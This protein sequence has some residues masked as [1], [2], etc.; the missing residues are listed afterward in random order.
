MTALLSEIGREECFEDAGGGGSCLLLLLCSTFCLDGGGTGGPVASWDDI[1]LL[2]VDMG[3][4]GGARLEVTV[5]RSLKHVG[6]F[7][8]ALS[9]NFCWHKC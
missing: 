8:V 5:C 3:V 4:C 1:S 2:P 9:Q 7:C 6:L